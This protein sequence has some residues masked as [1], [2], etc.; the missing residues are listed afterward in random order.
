MTLVPEKYY[1]PVG[2]PYE[3]IIGLISVV[4]G[5]ILFVFAGWF[6]F[7]TCSSHNLCKVPVLIIVCISLIFS[8]WFLRIAFNLLSGRSNKNKQLLSNFTLYLIGWF[9]LIC[10]VSL[11]ILFLSLGKDDH[12]FSF[13]VASS[14]ITSFLIGIG[15]L[16]LAKQRKKKRTSNN[17][18]SPER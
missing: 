11:T 8:I 10:S 1:K 14:M 18:I 15:A 9:F 13:N 2:R 17:A 5:L 6:I 12:S 3:F 4:V 7:G 16:S